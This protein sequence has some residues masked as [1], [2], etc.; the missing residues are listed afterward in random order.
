MTE[1]LTR[2][3]AGRAL[4][5]AAAAG[6][7]EHEVLSLRPPDARA[8]AEAAEAGIGV[9]TEAAADLMM[10]SADVVVV[11]FWNTAALT[12]FF[13]GEWPAMRLALWCHMAGDRAP[14]VLHEQL[15]AHIDCLIASCP[16]TAGHHPGA[17]MIEPFSRV[18]ASP[19]HEPAAFAVGHVGQLDETKLHPEFAAL[20]DGLACVAYG[21]GPLRRGLQAAGVTCPGWVEDVAGALASF[22]VL[23]HPLHPEA[24]EGTELSLQE[25]LLAGVP[26]VVLAGGGATGTVEPGVTGVLAGDEAGYRSAVIELAGDP[27][28]QRRLGAA[29]REAARERW[30]PGRL[31][32]RWAALYEELL[33]APKRERAP[34]AAGEPPAARFVASLGQTPAAAA[35]AAGDEHSIA[36]CSPQVRVA[37]LN[38]RDAHP[39]DASLRRWAGIVL[40]AAGR[41]ALAAGEFAAAA[42][43]GA[44]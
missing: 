1:A 38:H 3:G 15:L 40:A 31:A 19:R 18:P 39:D 22:S 36:A 42:R 34:L 13:A 7:G 28:R 27:D 8:A 9:R 14:H 37:L 11:H 41:N 21:D 24:G 32:G 43:L 44:P 25:A 6:P 17:V 12:D 29:A 16:Y 26:A 5:T 30:D 20:H 4:L 23:G 35:F 33:G 10:S 2:G